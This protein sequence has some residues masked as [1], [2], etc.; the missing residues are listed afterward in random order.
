M[1]PTTHK[2]V[3]FATV[4]AALLA[5][6][7]AA[8]LA[9]ARPASTSGCS[10]VQPPNPAWVVV[11]DEQGVP[12]LYPAGN[13]P[14]D[15]NCSPAGSQDGATLSTAAAPTHILPTLPTPA[16]WVSVTDD[17]GVPWLYPAGAQSG[18]PEPVAA[19]GRLNTAARHANHRV[20]GS[21]I[22][23]RRHGSV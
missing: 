19:K 22:S 18:Q 7:I 13:A 9:Q 16:G 12:W 20:T 14:Q 8:P 6:A 4:G 3:R 15:L 23:G 1:T 2:S 10:T 17:L 11:N 5:I 21:N